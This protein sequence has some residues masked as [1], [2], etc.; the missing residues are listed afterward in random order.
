MTPWS[1]DPNSRPVRRVSAE[2]WK[3]G[4]SA[5]NCTCPDILEASNGDFYVIGTDVTAEVADS[6]VD[7]ATC[8]PHE[9]IVMIPKQTLASAVEC[10]SVGSAA[11]PV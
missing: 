11:Q 8:G 3:L 5:T 4:I 6:L 7:G 1:S 10:L 2:P 9:R